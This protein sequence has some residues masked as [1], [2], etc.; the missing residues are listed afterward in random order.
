LE[1]DEPASRNHPTYDL[2][3][4][5]SNDTCHTGRGKAEIR[6]PGVLEKWIAD[7]RL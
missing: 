6:Y 7:L 3:N 1:S 5:A 4:S 2:K